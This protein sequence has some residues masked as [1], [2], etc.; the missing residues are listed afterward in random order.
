MGLGIAHADEGHDSDREGGKPDGTQGDLLL[1][2]A[3]SFPDL[4]TFVTATL[5]RT[6]GSADAPEEVT[7]A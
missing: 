1:A 6:V 2:H 7:T 5:W 4:G 3:G